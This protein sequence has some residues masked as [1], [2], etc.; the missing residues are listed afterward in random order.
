VLQDTVQPDARTAVSGVMDCTHPTITINGISSTQGVT[1][2]WIGLGSYTS[3]DQNLS[4]IVDGGYTL[5]VTNTSNGCI[6]TATAYV[7][8]NIELPTASAYVSGNLTCVV[9]SVQLTSSSATSGVS[10]SWTGP[11]FSSPVL[12]QNTT[13]SIGGIYTVTTTNPINGC[14]STSSVNVV[15]DIAKPGATI[16]ASNHIITCAAINA[17]LSGSSPSIGVTYS[18]SGPNLNLTVQNVTVAS[19]GTYVLTVNKAQNGCISRDTTIITVDKVR[20]VVTITPPNSIT[21]TSGVITLQGSSSV[22][23]E[24]SLYRWMG[25]SG[26][27]TLNGAVQTTS[28]AGG[29]ILSVTNLSNGCMTTKPTVVQQDVDLPAS[30]TA[31]N[32]GPLTCAVNNVM[33][34]GYSSTPGVNY[35]WIGPN[36]PYTG[37]TASVSASGTYTLVVTNPVNGCSANTTTSVAQNRTPPALV[38][39]TNNGP[40]T[41]SINSVTLLGNS[42]TSGVTY[43]WKNQAGTVISTDQ[44]HSVTESG[45]YSLVATNPSNGCISIKVTLVALNTAKPALVIAGNDG[46]LTCSV[47]SA[48]INGSSSTSDVTY[49]WTGPNNFNSTAKNPTVGTSG[50]YKL[51]VTNTQNGCT[52]TTSTFLAHNV[53][54]PGASISPVATL[55]CSLQS[56][57]IPASSPTDSVTYSWSGS[58]NFASTEKSPETNKPGDY[59]V[60]VTNSINKCMSYA[61]VT[62][63]QDNAVPT[64]VT[65]SAPDI[66]T[67]TRLSVSLVGNSTSSNV[68]YGWIGPNGNTLTGQNPIVT[69]KGNYLLTVTSQSN[70]CKSY[71][72]TSVAKDTTPPADVNASASGI[73]NCQNANVTLTGSTSTLGATYNWT[74][75]GLTPPSTSATQIT[76]FTGTYHLTVTNP[77]NG[78]TGTANVTVEE[79]HTSPAP[80]SASSSGVLTCSIPHVTVTASSSTSPAEYSWSGPAGSGFTSNEQTPSVGL[81]GAYTVTVTHP[82]SKCFAIQSTTVLQDT[83]SPANVTASA[84]GII[85]CYNGSVNLS[86]HSTTNG[87]TYRWTGP[88]GFIS[89]LQYPVNVD[90]AGLFTLKVTNPTNGCVKIRTLTVDADTTRPADVTAVASNKLGCTVTSATLT[91]YSSTPDVDYT[92]WYYGN[93]VATDPETD[94]NMEGDY[95]LNITNGVNGCFVEKTVTIVRDLTAPK[96]K[97][98]VADNSTV[99]QH[100]INTVRDTATLPTYGYTW[101]ITNSWTINS[102]QSTPT[103]T[104]QAGNAGTTS[105]IAV[106]VTDLTSGCTNTCSV[107]LS[108]VVSKSAISEDDLSAENVKELTLNTYPV[109]SMGKVFVEFASPEQTDASVTVYNTNGSV[110][111]NL[112]NQSAMAN[113]SY[114]LEFNQTETLPSGI[115]ICILKT[116]TKTMSHKIIIK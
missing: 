76:S 73:L 18:W 1:F 11:G 55:T 110:V 69:V 15:Q 44:N 23:P 47:L 26:F 112:F 91:G 98:D 85:N 46:P 116:K 9:N 33:L 106:L 60:T 75:P 34:T 72:S 77:Y 28:I 78:C 5:M 80:V 53:D 82:V 61:S 65:A 115:Y 66:L 32:N 24:S 102:G 97:L 96:C 42:A 31:S 62:I 114:K 88:G 14:Q 104:Y 37:I 81:P 7:P 108:A 38:T 94:V 100:T 20:P 70:G 22:P 58:D 49:I 103:L 50:T 36:G 52:D 13:T 54:L 56:V 12:A 10:Y 40:I 45:I 6:S 21:C 30:V 59:T 63:L 35:T 41:C 68:N 19:T 113:Q 48:T 89:D 2:R 93:L 79:N 86:G 17:N 99:V 92:W 87:V 51:T 27:G 83:I 29:Y 39:A 8:K 3:T 43:Q 107:N 105:H 74:G 109:P 25:P 67:C 4:V 84:D 71:A 95:L 90:K 16:T 101:T 64:G 111:A 57:T